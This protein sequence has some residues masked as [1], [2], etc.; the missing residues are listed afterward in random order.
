MRGSVGP[1]EGGRR[2]QRGETAPRAPNSGGARAGHASHAPRAAS[3][4][5]RPAPARAA[6][7]RRP[8]PACACAA[9]RAAPPRAW[10]AG[11][12]S[13]RDR[14]ARRRLQRAANAARR[15]AAAPRVSAVHALRSAVVWASARRWE[16]YRELT[17]DD[18]G[19][20]Q[21]EVRSMA[22]ET[23]LLAR[24]AFRLRATCCVTLV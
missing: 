22:R 14:P 7:P 4:S 2:D 24:C 21:V 1:S 20:S 8:P 23:K 10:P 12:Q 3:V 11:A 16:S 9:R 19:R 15:R 5:A 6:H 17:Q 13:P 18:E